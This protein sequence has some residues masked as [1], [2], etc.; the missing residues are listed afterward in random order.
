MDMCQL[1]LVQSTYR[2]V[3]LTDRFGLEIPRAAIIRGI[4][5]EVRR[6]GDDSVADNSVH[7]IKGGQ[8][9]IA[10]RALPDPWSADVTWVTY[11]GPDDLWGETWI[12]EDLDSDDFGLALSAAYSKNVGNTVAY[13]DVVRVTVTYQRTCD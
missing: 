3:L 13:V 10:E 9:G 6:A 5:V 12:A 11:G 4:T 2:D 8:I 7:I 1:I